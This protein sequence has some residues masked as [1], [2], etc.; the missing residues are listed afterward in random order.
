MCVVY[1]CMWVEARGEYWVHFL[2]LPYCL[3]TAGAQELVGSFGRDVEE[4]R[5]VA[6]KHQ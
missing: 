5:L 3:E 2:S 1:E 6:S 4:T